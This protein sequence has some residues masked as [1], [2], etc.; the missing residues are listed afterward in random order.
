[1]DFQLTNEQMEFQKA[2]REFAEKELAPGAMQRD[3][4]GDFSGIYDILMKKMAPMGLL[5]LT[6]PKEYGGLGKSYIEFALAMIE[7]CRIEVSFGA[8]WSVCMS[9]G[10]VPIWRFG[11]EEQKK[12]YLVPLARGEK[13]CAFGLT[14]PKAGSD[15]AMQETTAVLDGND[16][17][18]N[19]SKIY[20]TNAGYADIYI[21]I[22][23][24]DKSKGT[25][26]ISA[27]I[28]EKGTP[29]FTF[30]KEYKK[31][32]IRASVQQELV[33]ENCRIPKENMIG[34]E[35]E[36]FKIA[37]TALDVG[38]LGVASQGVGAAMGAY[39]LA[40]KYAKG[41]IQF[42]KPVTAN[43]GVSFMLADMA[44]Q[45][46]LAQLIVLK[47]AWLYSNGLPFSKEVAMAKSYCTD[48]AMKVTT[49]AVQIFGGKG[50]LVEN[51][52]ERFMRDAKILQIYEGTN[53]IQRLVI[54][55]H[56]LK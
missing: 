23:M 53:Q 17:I 29:G 31:M 24:T 21:V 18:L 10:T 43:Q 8:S 25:K 55:G 22:A 41:R 27:F 52:V 3:L 4:D 32:G 49:D 28:V 30:G 1:M 38:R 26:G 36:G 7:F 20:I 13:L 19:G 9:L 6:F 51:E 39:D 44:T 40:L 54:A 2:M 5:G 35:G 12:K 11:S 45:I 33:F 48:V 37:M 47:A 42:G 14:E 34:K 15:S 50:Y 16:Y 46:E 56:I